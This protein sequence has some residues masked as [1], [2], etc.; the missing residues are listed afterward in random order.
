MPRSSPRFATPRDRDR[1]TRGPETLAH[2]ARLRRAPPYPWQWEVADVAGE[3]ADDGVGFRYPVVLVSVPRRAGKTTLTLAAN[4]DRLD[5]IGDARGWYTANRREV[6]AKLFRDEWAPMVDT[7]ALR[8]FYRLRRSQGS[9]GIHKRHGSSR[10]QLFAPTADAL[11]S[12]NADTITIDEAWAFDS[13]SG[14][15]LEAGGR[16]AQLT[17]PWRQL[18]IVS[19]G[20]TIESTWWDRWLTAGEQATP[21][22]ALF[23]YGADPAADGYDPGNPAVWAAAHPLAAVSPIVGEAIAHEWATR[24][25]DATFE[26]GIL[27]VWPRPSL[28]VAA[29]GVELAHWSAAA[30]PAAAPTVQAIALDVAADRSAAALAVAGDHDGRLTVEVIDH[31]PGVA[32]LAAAAKAARGRWRGVPVVADSLVAASIVAELAKAKV[33][34]E[35]VG[36]SDHARAC[37]TFVD[38]LAAGRLAHRS[39][40]VLDDAVAGAA[41]RPLGDAWLWSRARSTVD[42]SPLVAVTLAAWRA[43]GHAPTGKAAVI[44]TG[45]PVGA[46]SGADYRIARTRHTPGPRFAQHRAT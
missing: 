1:A 30:A 7:R 41:R 37:G 27:N 34:V 18:W 32:W 16:F 17:R 5:L 13:P 8:R 25:D 15:A 36:A 33:P 45:Q 24:A 40:A 20:G 11:H 6:A 46:S 44:V 21:G 3:L 39:Q 12:T 9:E 28:V 31:R 19:A 43:H 23:D 14:E 29:A 22:V 4:L 26:R 35:P 38:L 42:I 2:L 10:L